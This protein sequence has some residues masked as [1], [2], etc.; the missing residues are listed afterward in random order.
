MYDITRKS[1]FDNLSIWYEDCKS[2]SPKTVV[3]ILIGNKVDLEHSREVTYE[4]GSDFAKKY[5]M[6]FFETSALTNLNIN[7]VR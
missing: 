7:E 5:N 6:L 1:S 2:Q 3:L 4:Q